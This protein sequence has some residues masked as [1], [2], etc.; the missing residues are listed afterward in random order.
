[1]RTDV[2]VAH[3]YTVWFS[4]DRHVFQR[5]EWGGCTVV[6]TRDPNRFTR[7]LALHL[8]GH[9]APSP[10][11]LRTDGVVAVHDDRAIVLPPSLRQEVSIYERPLREAG[12]VLHDGP[13]V[14]FDPGTGE[15]ALEPP[16]LPASCFDAVVS[17]LP[18]ARRPDRIAEFGRYPV[19]YWY[20]ASLTAKHEPM[21]VIDAVTIALS[22]LRSPLTERGQAA[23]VAAMF[24]RTP[25][26]WLRLP[27]PKELI[28]LIA[29]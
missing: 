17:A 7:A 22:R 10:G 28:G 2:A 19:A 13:W 1:M 23:M 12:I 20:F 16:P 8:S 15:V 25:F 4:T 29:S 24:E 5:L 21:A 26:G 6:R 14:D 27:G 3:N 18:P 11:L 9:G